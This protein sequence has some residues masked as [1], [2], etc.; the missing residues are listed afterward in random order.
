MYPSCVNL[1]GSAKELD[2]CNLIEFNET[3]NRPLLDENLE[4]IVRNTVFVLFAFIFVAGLIGNALVIIGEYTFV[5]SVYSFFEN[6][7][8]HIK[9]INLQI[10]FFTVV[11]F[12]PLMRST[13]NTLIINLAIS[14]LVFVI[15]C[16]PFTGWSEYL[17]AKLF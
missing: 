13:T 3:H 17:K 11:A 8:I 14:D 5:L 4:H 12:N 7:Q 6:L 1:T 9:I 10:F 2:I 15:M 16:I